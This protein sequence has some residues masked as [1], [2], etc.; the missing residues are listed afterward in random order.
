M[1]ATVPK[2]FVQDDLSQKTDWNL[3][4]KNYVAAWSS[5]TG[6]GFTMMEGEKTKPDGITKY[7][8][9]IIT[10][11]IDSQGCTKKNVDGV[12]VCIKTGHNLVF[13]CSYSLEDQDL[14]SVDLTVSGS[15]SEATAVNTGTLTYTLG[16][17]T[18]L[19]IGDVATATITPK[20]AGLVEATVTECSVEHDQDGNSAT[21]PQSV[22]L[23]NSGVVP[24]FNPLG[25]G[26]ATGT[27]LD[28]LT[29]SWNSFKWT[30]T[31]KNNA[32]VVESQH[33]KCKISLA[34]PSSATIS[35]ILFL[36]SGG[37]RV[38]HLVGEHGQLA[39]TFATNDYYAYAGCGVTHQN[40]HY[41]F[42][43]N[44]SG[45]SGFNRRQ[46]LQID[47]CGLTKLGDLDFDHRGASCGSNGNEIFLCFDFFDQRLCRTASSPTGQFND[48]ALSKYDHGVAAIGVSPNA[49]LAL[50]SSSGHQ[51]G[52]LLVGGSWSDIPDYPHGSRYIFNH[53]IVYVEDHDAFYVIGGY[54][55]DTGAMTI[56]AWQNG[57]W[58]DKGQVV[59]NRWSHSA[60]WNGDA[61]VI[62][63]G[64][65]EPGSTDLPTEHCK[66]NGQGDF[67][68]EEIAPTLD[69]YDQGVAF[70]VSDDFCLA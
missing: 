45:A 26:I 42:G 19:K 9:L 3:V 37:S 2:D 65:R 64:Y 66:M 35:N 30:T 61:L 39:T 44:R 23:F 10:K 49:V 59:N 21:T 15:D 13:E 48:V 11:T 25:V 1:K 36:S 50:G 57:Q 54:D 40:T 7:R 63:G 18:G 32:D 70:S 68:C 62:L 38:P 46:I 60:I 33:L 22:G 34:L 4:D 47:G 20:T 12:N 17:N 55:G 6:D 16:V 14:D 29:F 41:V 58:Q 56:G 28:A 43:G 8:A 51:K 5:F 69:G 67:E 24:D 52:E 53:R 27:G 31:K